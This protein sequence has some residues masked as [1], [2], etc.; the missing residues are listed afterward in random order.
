MQ[1]NAQKTGDVWIIQIFTDLEN[2]TIEGN[3]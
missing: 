3:R 2:A 1:M